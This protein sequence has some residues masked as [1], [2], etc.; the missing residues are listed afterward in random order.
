MSVVKLA[1][2]SPPAAVPLATGLARLVEQ[3][4]EIRTEAEG[5]PMSGSDRLDLRSNLLCA[6]KS[7]YRATQIIDD[8]E[9][10]V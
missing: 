7:L 10:G 6:V 3:L 2:P 1:R 9:K 8:A 5:I 4:F